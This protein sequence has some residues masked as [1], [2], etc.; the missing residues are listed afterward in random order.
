MK[1]K[2]EPK[3]RAP[4]KNDYENF[5]RYLEA[6]QEADEAREALR[7]S[8]HEFN[9]VTH[10]LTLPKEIKFQVGETSAAL[11]SIYLNKYGNQIGGLI[12]DDSLDD[13]ASLDL[14]DYDELIKKRNATK[15][16]NG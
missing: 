4:D 6:R 3:M 8:R 10:I 1:S 11:H 2:T 14:E 12:F 16:D 5:M 13:F 7:K 15:R 9:V